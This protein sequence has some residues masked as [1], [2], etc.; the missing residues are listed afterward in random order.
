[1]P[2]FIKKNNSASFQFTLMFNLRA[3]EN[4][5]LKPYSIYCLNTYHRQSIL[6]NLSHQKIDSN[7]YS[8]NY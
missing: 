5:C 2:M 6:K 8:S 4:Q 7:Y 3:I 1:M